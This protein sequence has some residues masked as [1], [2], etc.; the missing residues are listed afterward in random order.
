MRKHVSLIES[1][2]WLIATAPVISPLIKSDARTA[3]CIALGKKGDSQAD[4]TL[5][6]CEAS[7]LFTCYSTENNYIKQ[8]EMDKYMHSYSVQ[9][10]SR[11]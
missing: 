4:I 10:Q 8:R 5:F 6:T 1:L 7:Y 11:E 2:S 9:G 3:V